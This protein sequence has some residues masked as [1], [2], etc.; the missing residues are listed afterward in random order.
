L[1]TISSAVVAVG[2]DVGVGGTGVA[3]GGVGGGGPHDDSGMARQMAI[4]SRQT[5][6]LLILLRL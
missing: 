3:V 2:G 6:G 4:N 1:T 5:V